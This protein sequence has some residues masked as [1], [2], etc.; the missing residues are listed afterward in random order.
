MKKFEFGEGRVTEVHKKNYGK[1][2]FGVIFEIFGLNRNHMKTFKQ[3][4]APIMLAMMV[5]FSATAC[6]KEENIKPEDIPAA[7]STFVS[8]YFPDLTISHAKKEKDGL[9]GRE[10]QVYLNNGTE[11]DFDKNGV[12]IEVDGPANEAIPTGFILDPIVAYVAENYDMVAINSIS[13]ERNGFEVELTN[14]FDLEF[15]LNG[16]FVRMD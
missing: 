16:A 6:D 5:I 10:Y 15:D 7:A 11:I 13:K 3:T 14:G 2:F 1:K 4:I 9:F 8:T 12:W